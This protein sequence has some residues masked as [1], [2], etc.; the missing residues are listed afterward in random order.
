MPS[1]NSE[2]NFIRY[3]F[4]YPFD[5]SC[6]T[7]GINVA[8]LG[9]AIPLSLR[10]KMRGLEKRRKAFLALEETTS[11]LRLAEKPLKT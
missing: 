4:F 2:Q 8:A 5:C 3:A 10:T 11:I 9:E 1:L 7:V 6:V